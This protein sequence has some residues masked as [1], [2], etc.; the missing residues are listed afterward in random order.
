[1][2]NRKRAIKVH[3]SVYHLNHE[4]S[5]QGAYVYSSLNKLTVHELERLHDAMHSKLNIEEDYR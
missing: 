4:D 1:M 5:L 3:L 2:S